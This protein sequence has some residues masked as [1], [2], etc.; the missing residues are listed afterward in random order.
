[1]EPLVS[2]SSFFASY[3]AAVEAQPTIQTATMDEAS[4]LRA[5]WRFSFILGVFVKYSVSV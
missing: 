2:V 3:A 5:L 1:M 4:R